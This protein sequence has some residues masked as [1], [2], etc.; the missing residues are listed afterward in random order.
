[1]GNLWLRS[2]IRGLIIVPEWGLRQIRTYQYR[3]EGVYTEKVNL[4]A[5]YKDARDHVW[6]SNMADVD[7]FS[8]KGEKVAR[9]ENVWQVKKIVDDP[10]GGPDHCW[11]VTQDKELLK[12]VQ[13]N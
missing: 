3:I 10:W 8:Q 9:I 11:M 2:G 6:I 7:I 1:M 12:V 13:N 4:R 5:I